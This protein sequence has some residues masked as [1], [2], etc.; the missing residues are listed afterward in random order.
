VAA[1]TEREALEALHATGAVLDGHFIL[2]SGKHAGRYVQCA[3]LLQ[4]PDLAQ[5]V[6]QLLGE[7]AQACGPIDAVVGPAMGGIVVAYE[8]ARALGVRGLFTE[9]QNGQMTLRRGFEIKESERVLIAEDVVTT[10][11]SSLE[12]ANVLTKCG[13]TILGIA[14][15][16]DRRPK[17]TE[18]P[19]S[20]VSAIRLEIDAFE[21]EDCPLCSQGIP[22]VKPGSRAFLIISNQ[23]LPE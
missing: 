13:A 15:I 9:R 10:G 20:L 19:L 7:R 6:C 16:V 17:D 23:G 3:R 2:S 1:P 4:H 11:G 8:L 21:P 12:V 5:Q 22:A 14:C 18:L